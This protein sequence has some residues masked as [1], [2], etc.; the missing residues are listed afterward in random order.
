MTDDVLICTTDDVP[1]YRVVRV[2]GLVRGFGMSTF[3]INRPLWIVR[4]VVEDAIV[5]LES[6]TRAV[7]ANAVIGARFA[8]SNVDVCAYGT[9]VVVAKE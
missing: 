2:I 9:A 5:D 7:G 6:T 3:D 8:A 1:G 4:E